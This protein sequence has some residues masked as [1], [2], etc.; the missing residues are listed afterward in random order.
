MLFTVEDEAKFTQYKPCLQN[1]ANAVAIVLEN[2]QQ[3][4]LL[5]DENVR[6]DRA[7][8]ERTSEL[9]F[10]NQQLVANEQHLRS[11]NQQL[12]ANEQHLR[13]ANQQL[14]ANEQHLR[15]SNQQ[16]AA[17]EQ[18]LRASNQQLAAHEQQLRAA[19]Q[20]LAASEEHLRVLFDQAAD[21]I[22][23]SKMNGQLL[24]VNEQACLA[25][26]YTK[27]ELL[28]FN[29]TDVDAEMNTPDAFHQFVATLSPGRPVTIE[30]KHRRKD[31][32]TFPVEITISCIEMPGGRNIVGIARDITVRKRAE[33]DLRESEE[34][35]RSLVEQS[36]VAIQIFNPD[37]WTIQVNSA[38]IKLWDFSDEALQEVYE[39]YNILQ[40]EQIIKLGVMSLVEKTFAG[41]V[42]LVPPL[43]YDTHEM[44]E[45][46]SYIKIEGRKRWIQPQL[47]PVKNKNG[48]IL[49]VTLMMEDI[50]DRKKAEQE[51]LAK[52]AQLK[53]LASQLSVTEERE[54]RRIATELHDQIGQSLVFSKIKL[55]ELHQSATSSELT[56]ALDQI[57]NNIGQIIQ[58]TRSLTFELSSPILNELGLEAA[59]AE[60][61]DV[62][63]REKYSIETEFEDDGQQKPLDED[64][65]A[66]MFRNVRELLVNVIK[67]ANANKV[68]VSIGRVN[69]QI[70]ID[71][72][73]DGK[74]FD[75]VKVTSSAAKD[76]KFGLFSIRQ[77]LEQLGGHFEI[78]S[79]PGR[80]S[81]FSMTVPLKRA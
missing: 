43:E 60:W 19:N 17:D 16:L 22:Y 9:E 38:F 4:K 14:A 7:V 2:R 47:F 40:D 51:I 29:V 49:N 79:E 39:K 66:L 72:E 52:Q 73:D 30:S 5:A 36:P 13:S 74:G 56:K 59:V 12:A 75:A 31:G 55:D 44:M 63:I 15:A 8:K 81:K 24:Q 64:I 46:N 3:A 69:E 58:D 34:Q 35:F 6:L 53:S 42:V 1:F 78:D 23:V 18:Q 21:A 57:R 67:H 37:G 65:Q 48:E 25:I 10:A 50:T 61:L 27:E 70:H 28:G 11:A 54:R 62:Q 77:R 26:G 32:S 20:Q 80:G 33:E 71:V 68:K 45:T 76:T 41:E